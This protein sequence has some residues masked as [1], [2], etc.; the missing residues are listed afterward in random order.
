MQ[1]KMHPDYNLTSHPE[2][3]GKLH[4]NASSVKFYS[5]QMIDRILS[6]PV[7]TVFLSNHGALTKSIK[8]FDLIVSGSIADKADIR[9]SRIR[10]A[11]TRPLTPQSPDNSRDCVFTNCMLQASSRTIRTRCRLSKVL[12]SSIPV[13]TREGRGTYNESEV[14]L[15]VHVSNSALVRQRRSQQAHQSLC[16]VSNAL[17]RSL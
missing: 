10:R 11:S 3:S 13:R 6:I 9:Q 12:N 8:T 5:I 15:D 14:V 17:H 4:S 7:V 1:T 16:C 2:R